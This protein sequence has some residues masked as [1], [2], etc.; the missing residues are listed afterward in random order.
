[1]KTNRKVLTLVMASGLLVPA[2]I[3]SGC[4][5]LHGAAI[6]ESVE[7][8]V[9]VQ[10]EGI[11]VDGTGEV[12]VVPDVAAVNLGVQAESSTVAEAQELASRAMDDVI[13]ALLDHG[14]TETDIQTTGFTIRQLTQRDPTQ[15]RDRV[16][17][18]QVSN[19][20]R[21]MIREVDDAGAILD[22]VVATG[23]DY[24]RVHGISFMLDDPSVHLEAARTNAVADAR[25]KAEQLAQ[26]TGVQLGDPVNISETSS[27]PSLFRGVE[28]VSHDA[29]AAPPTPIEPGEITVT[30]SVN[31]VY[32]IA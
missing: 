3:L 18:Y 10:E 4:A 17:G 30:A 26:L 15:P 7:V 11:S 1:M 23:G 12:M 8:R 27:T 19:N 29:P 21:V 24:I 22:A 13:S 6:G 20:L 16:T 5:P 25:S 2:F 31:I 28:R 32:A 14:V 9:A